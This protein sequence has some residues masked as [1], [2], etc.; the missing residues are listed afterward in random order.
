MKLQEYEAKVLA[1][2]Y[3][4][5]TPPG[6]V[7]LSPEE[8]RQIAQ[9]LGTTVLTKAQ[10]PFKGRAKL[11]G[12]KEANSPAQAECKARELIGS[13]LNQFKV[14][15]VLVEEKMPM[16]KELYFGISIDRSSRTYIVVGSPEGGVEIENLAAANPQ[17]FRK[18]TVDPLLGF[19][20]FQARQLAQ[21]MGY[22]GSKM[23]ELARIFLCFYKLA[24]DNDA[25][26]VESNP[27]IETTDGKFV[28]ADPRV[29]IDDDALYRH[30]FFKERLKSEWRELPPHEIE[31]KETELDYVKLEGNVGILGNGAGLVMASL[32][33]VRWFGGKP[34]DFLDIGG[35][36]PVD[37]VVAALNVVLSDPRVDGVFINILGGITR[38]DEVAKGILKA[39]Q[40]FNFSK[41]IVTRL[42]GTNEEEG[43]RILKDGDISVYD[44]MEAAAEAI[45]RIIKKK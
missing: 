4:I 45:V 41:P 11:G 18:I 32:D 39:K 33:S 23:L 6:R 35:G 14:E 20:A 29:V 15:K 24:I 16:I 10:V 38:C 17:K 31:A 28:A 12:V 2:K 22:G 44:N 26:L 42:V 3:G 1:E 40:W 25:E 8:A 37:K 21:K 36:A 27:I 13:T 19:Q 30:E 43:K 9:E 7:A 34:A 5:P